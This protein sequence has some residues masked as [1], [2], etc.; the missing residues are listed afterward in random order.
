M[1]TF[2]ERYI[3]GNVLQDH[4]L[5]QNQYAYQTGKST[6]TTLAE[7]KNTCVECSETPSDNLMDFLWHGWI[8]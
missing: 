2:I 8:I 5:H 3:R 4:P 6:E 7:P 1:V